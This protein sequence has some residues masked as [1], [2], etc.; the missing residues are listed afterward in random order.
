MVDPKHQQEL[1]RQKQ[2]LKLKQFEM[3]QQTLG[4]LNSLIIST[5]TLGDFEVLTTDELNVDFSSTIENYDFD[6]ISFIRD[7]Q[8]SNVNSVQLFNLSDKNAGS[9][10]NS[11]N[12]GRNGVLQSSSSSWEQFDHFNNYD[13]EQNDTKA[14]TTI[15]NANNEM[16]FIYSVKNV[17]NDNQM[18]ISA[19]IESLKNGNSVK[20]N[21]NHIHLIMNSVQKLKEFVSRKV[22]GAIIDQNETS[23]SS[24]TTLNSN[25]SNTNV[26]RKPQI[27]LF[28]EDQLT[29][30][31]STEC[32]KLLMQLFEITLGV[33]ICDY[34]EKRAGNNWPYRANNKIV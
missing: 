6:N 15:F 22:F 12:N 19:V 11:I 26:N 1:E 23:A 28:S 3:K 8:M 5:I 25:E 17:Q 4:A 27:N 2:E 21:Y 31:S 29:V 13:S 20:P 9:L 34:K 18:S 7:E 16:S 30:L 33:L 10:M 32:K 14:D 24:E